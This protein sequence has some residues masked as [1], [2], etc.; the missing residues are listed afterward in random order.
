[1]SLSKPVLAEPPGSWSERYGERHRLVRIST[2]PAGIQ[3][4]KKVRIYQRQQHFVLQWWD[5]AARRNLSDRVDGDLVAAIMRARQI[6]E[7]LV[8]F[9]SSGQGRRRIGHRELVE[10]FRADLERRA[11]AGEIDPRTVV[12]YASALGH[13]LA[14]AGQPRVAAEFASATSVNREFALGLAAHLADTKIS[15]NG[16]PNSARRRMTAPAYVEDVVRTMFTWAADP[17]RAN[18]MPTGFRNPFAG[19]RR[20]T[21]DVARD[22]FGEPDVT[23]TMAAEFLAA[24]DAFQLPLFTPVSYTHLTLPT[25]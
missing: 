8:H 9:K 5:P 3:V 13:Y 22:L 10:Q 15:P 7:R 14:Y 1:M 11:D 23:I 6:E 25:N 19:K 20:R 18:L 24:C 4:P 21:S 12:R 16:H 2:F 17:D